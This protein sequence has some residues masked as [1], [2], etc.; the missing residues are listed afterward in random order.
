MRDAR[1]TRHLAVEAGAVAATGAVL[2]RLLPG[3][4]AQV[5]ADPATWAA[6][7]PQVEASLRRAGVA[8]RPCRVLTASPA[9]HAD[10][11][12]VEALDAAFAGHQA[13]PVAVGAGTINDLVKLAAHRAGRPYV[14]VATAASMDG[15]AAYGAS[16]TRDGSKQTQPCPAP[17]AI[18]ADPPLLAAAPPAL[19]AAGYG[20]LVA[21]VVA[22]AD[23]IL[24]DALEIEAIHPAA[25]ELAQPP[26]RRCIAD[27]GGLARR[28]PAVFADLLTG[29]VR[30]GLAM[31]VARS[32]RPASGADHQFSHLWDME[33]GG[34]AAAHGFK[35]GIGTLASA[36][37]YEQLLAEDIDAAVAARGPW[38]GWEE[39]AER[40]A[41]LH[42]QPAIRAVALEETRAKHPGDAE[43]RRR[44]AL[45]RERWP[46]L[47]ERLAAQLLPA[48][49][50]RTMLAAAGAPVDP[51]L[52]GVAPAHLRASHERARTIRRRYTILDLAEELGTAGRWRER[53]FAPG[54]FWGGPAGVSAR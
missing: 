4:E 31:Q 21:K 28:D 30:T 39:M 23:W 25:W 18:I 41:A 8:L 24:A 47:R 20:D 37:L 17:L 49:T 32:S 16:I 40:I 51:A 34:H 48:R 19:A 35:V 26:L 5:V 53:L 42:P 12:H 52:I 9:L 33:G 6:A 27:P 45:L 10:W 3:R 22:G 43:L 46:A 1:D 29:L 50:L 2:A 11:E 13:I 44:L 38:P 54:G 15:Y 14:A 36:A 7:G